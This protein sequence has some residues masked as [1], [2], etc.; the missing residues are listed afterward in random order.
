ML[1]HDFEESK[2][3]SH[4]FGYFWI[5]NFFFADSK[6]STSTRIWIQIEFARPHVSSDT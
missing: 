2:A 4:V 3:R 6:I 1:P 5:R